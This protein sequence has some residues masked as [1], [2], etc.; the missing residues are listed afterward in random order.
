MTT[1]PD[2]NAETLDTYERA[3]R[4]YRERTVR[5]DHETDDLVALVTA[6]APAGATVLEVGS[7][8][9]HDADRLE[10]L[11]FAVRRTDAA[12]AFVELQR[13]DGH[14]IDVLDVRT[15]DLGGPYDVVFAQAVL[16]HI[17]RAELPGVLARALAAVRPGGLLALT[18]KEGDGEEWSSH[19]VE[20]PRHFTYWRVEPLRAALVGAGWEPVVLERTSSSYGP[21]L[22]ALSRRSAG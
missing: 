11:G 7:G 5:H 15:D 8:P 17:D 20:L 21:W 4:L 13:A 12:R 22:R 1:G 16:L 19:K 18:L 14:E 2:A 9:G 10:A 3:A 6:H